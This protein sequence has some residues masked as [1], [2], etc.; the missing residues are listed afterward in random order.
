VIAARV[1]NRSQLGQASRSSPRHHQQIA[2]GELLDQP[3]KLR[4]VGLGSALHFQ[5]HLAPRS[6]AAALAGSML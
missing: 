2:G 1:F 3:A 6:E 4:P 5:Q